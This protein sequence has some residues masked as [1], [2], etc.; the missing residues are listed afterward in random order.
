LRRSDLTEQPA[1]ASAASDIDPELREYLR[2]WRREMAREQ[3]TPAFVV[4]HDASLEEVCRKQ[5]ISIP[6]LLCVSGFGERKAGMYGQEIFEALRRFREGLRA[7]AMPE[8]QSRPAEETIR[9]LAKGCSFE[10]I[11]KT[12]G[13]RITTVV[14]MVASL[15]E[16]G[17]LE[18]Q[19]GWVDMSRQA[20]IEDVCAC[21]GV[22]RLKPLK[23]ALPPE[24]S[25]DEIRLVVAKLRR[26]Q[27]VAASAVKGLNC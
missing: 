21:L 2:Q 12:R 20:M 14:S 17:E 19:R 23:D 27:Y 16:K 6:E 3:G 15:I 25:F 24:I 8:K 10:E 11:A 18:F 7:T 26:Q 9:M 22:E 13:R 4:M 5:P 1:K